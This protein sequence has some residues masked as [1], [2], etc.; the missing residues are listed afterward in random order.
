[1]N[2]VIRLATGEFLMAEGGPGDTLESVA[3]EYPGATGVASFVSL[4]LAVYNKL[5]LNAIQENRATTE[6]LE[7]LAGDLVEGVDS[8][9][10]G[11]DRR[12]HIGC[13]L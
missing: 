3:G 2:H 13:R 11:V 10:V 9:G 5:L 6:Y 1:M 12:Y 8:D 7:R 4:R